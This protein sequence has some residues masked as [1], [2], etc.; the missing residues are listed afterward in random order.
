MN[1][2]RD[3]NAQT[4]ELFKALIAKAHYILKAGTTQ[5]QIALIRQV[6]PVLMK[7][8]QAQKE[9]DENSEMRE[10][11][12]DLFSDTRAMLEREAPPAPPAD[13]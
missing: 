12:D 11:L 2:P 4:E 6:V 1:D 8:M 7:E 13:L 3:I 10:A 9:A 5:N